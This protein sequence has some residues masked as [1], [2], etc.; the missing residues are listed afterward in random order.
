[1]EDFESWRTRRNK[2]R[3][4]RIETPA[5]PLNGIHLHH[6]ADYEPWSD[7]TSFTH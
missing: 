3:L 6:D 7:A 2:A 4:G 1:M 5:V